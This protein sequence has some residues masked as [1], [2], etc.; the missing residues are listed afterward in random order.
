LGAAP[1]ATGGC[2][3]TGRGKGLIFGKR[4]SKMGRGGE[5]VHTRAGDQKRRTRHA[6]LRGETLGEWRAG[7]EGD[8]PIIPPTKKRNKHQQ[9]KGETLEYP[10]KGGQGGIWSKKEGRA[11]PWHAGATPP[12][13]TCSRGAPQLW[14]RGGPKEQKTA[15]SKG[16]NFKNKSHRIFSSGGRPCGDPR[17]DTFRCGC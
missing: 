11:H 4:F 14:G 15:R 8:A 5:G 3:L 16:R 2:F 7:Q 17:I 1:T 13:V 12:H 9:N 10:A 6:H